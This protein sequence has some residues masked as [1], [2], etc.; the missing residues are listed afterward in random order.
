MLLF[1]R[2]INTEIFC[3]IKDAAYMPICE[4][5]RYCK[6]ETHYYKET[7]RRYGTIRYSRLYLRLLKRWRDDQPNLENGT[8][9]RKNK[10]KTKTE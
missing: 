8:E 5:I 9:T 6:Q 4:L 2:G 3:N 1:D 7:V 10:I